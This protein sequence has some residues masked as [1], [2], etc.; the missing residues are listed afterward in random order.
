MRIHVF[1]FLI[2]TGEKP[3]ECTY[4]QC[5]KRFT[6]QGNF[7]SH[8]NLHKGKKEFVCTFKDC[9]KKYALESRLNIHIRTHVFLNFT[10]H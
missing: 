3:F 9:N 1:T 6:T 7:K 8:I 4:P 2:K 10:N 5:R